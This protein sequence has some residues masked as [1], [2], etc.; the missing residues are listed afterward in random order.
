[1]VP[2]MNFVLAAMTSHWIFL[3][4]ISMVRVQ[5]S[6]RCSKAKTKRNPFVRRLHSLKLFSG[7]AITT[8]I[9]HP[10]SKWSKY[11]KSP[12]GCSLCSKLWAMTSRPLSGPP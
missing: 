9:G 10:K 11:Y 8:D 7:L 4:S 3:V 6:L 12:G 1:M 5:F 2:G